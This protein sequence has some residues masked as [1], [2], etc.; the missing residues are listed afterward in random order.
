MTFYLTSLALRRGIIEFD[1][2]VLPAEKGQ[3]PYV[4]GP[5]GLLAIIGKDAFAAIE[6]AQA[7]CLARKNA[8]IQ[9]HKKSLES[10]H[11]R[12]DVFPVTPLASKNHP[13]S[14]PR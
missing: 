12:P 3:T 8:A 2:V 10:A 7:D 5:N 9:R 1:G 14:S 6:D 13:P 11:A 4:Q